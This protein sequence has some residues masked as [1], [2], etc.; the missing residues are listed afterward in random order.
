MNKK[1]KSL[2]E[3]VEN[4]SVMGVRSMKNGERMVRGGIK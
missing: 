4:N 1:I 3:T 2:V